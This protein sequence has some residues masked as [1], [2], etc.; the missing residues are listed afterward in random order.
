MSFAEVKF[1]ET[2][3][4]SGFFLETSFRT[5]ELLGAVSPGYTVDDDNI[6]LLW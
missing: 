5:L 3:T 6:F 1:Q 4:R 2:E